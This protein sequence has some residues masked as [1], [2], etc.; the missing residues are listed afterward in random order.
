MGSSKKF[1]QSS[2]AEEL[3]MSAKVAGLDLIDNEKPPHAYSIWWK[4]TRKNHPA[5]LLSKTP[6]VPG[7]IPHSQGS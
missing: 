3:F 7:S 5:E 2:R 1:E 4:K 6:P